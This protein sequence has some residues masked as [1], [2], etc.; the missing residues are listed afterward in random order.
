MLKK[1]NEKLIKTILIFF[2]I[3]LLTIPSNQLAYSQSDYLNM[4]YIFFGN[5]STYINQVN[6]TKGSLNEVSPNYF[7]V[8]EDGN[9]VIT[10]KLQA[11]FISEMHRRGIRVVPFLSNHWNATAGINSLKNRDKLAQDIATAIKTYNLDGVN[12]DIEGVSHAYR[13][14]H[15]DFIRLLRK[16]LGNKK[17]ISVSVAANPN[18]WKTGWHGFYDYKGISDHIDYLMIMAYDES[19][20]GPDSP[21]GPVSSISFSERSIQY[22]LNQGVPKEKVVYGLPFYGR[23]WKLDGPTL[24]NLTITGSGLSSPTIE[25]L[26]TKYNAKII[27]D[28]KVQ[29]PYA[30]FTIP[31]GQ[32]SFVGSKKLTEGKYVIW[33]EDERSIK[34]KLQLPSKYGIKGT[35]SWALAHETPKTWE[36]Y[37]LWLNRRYFA[38]V[39]SDYWAEESINYV[40]KKGWMNGYS[41][42]AFSPHTKITRAQGAVILVR[43]LGKDSLEPKEYKFSDTKGYWAQREIEIA[44]ELGYL[45][46]KSLNIF[47]PS[48]PLTREQLAQILYNIFQFPLEENTTDPF[49]DVSY[50]DSSF[51]PIVSIYQK[52]YINGYSDG[53]FRP[54]V[55]TTRAQM[56]KIMEGMASDIEAEKS[57]E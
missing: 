30:S 14:V 10:W 3:M 41:S 36:Y 54:R 55:H 49:T 24:E 19:W 53:T 37:S 6:A 51:K 45:R 13:D 48:V 40:S 2:S 29:T 35:G 47:D 20:E 57:G 52:G 17:V 56:A 50:E 32:S 38:D 4:S 44:R 26:I 46:G 11:S 18:G 42:T 1:R 43:A 5:P 7:D 12:V 21:I 31:A 33:Y 22:A 34:A 25:S 8:T 27:F 16:Y 28:E 39:P 9:L 15:T 23:I